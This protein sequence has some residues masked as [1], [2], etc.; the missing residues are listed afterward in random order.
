MSYLNFILS[1]CLIVSSAFAGGAAAL[2]G[3]KSVSKGYTYG[4][5][6]E[7]NFVRDCRVDAN[8]NVCKCV[9]EKI[10]GQ[11]SEKEYNQIDYDLGRNISHPDF[12]N[13]V[14]KASQECDAYN[15][16]TANPTLK[17]DWAEDVNDYGDAVAD[18]EPEVLSEAE[19]REYVDNFSKNLPKEVLVSGR[20][21]DT[22]DLWGEKIAKKI[23]GC[24]YDHIVNDKQRFIAYIMENGFPEEDTWG[25]EY[26][27]ECLP[28]K[29]PPEFKKNYVDKLNK[30]GVPKS[31]AQCMMNIV[32]KEYTLKNFCSHIEKR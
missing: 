31:I 20:I 11:Y 15:L 10:K 6:T 19:V 14:S 32:E 29:Y 2:V 1:T 8:E 27:I 26:I 17:S 18:D 3:K 12:V 7:M 25:E 21:E 16:S 28:E 22:K 24:A 5:L 13:F 23:Y 9:L 4:V 30:M